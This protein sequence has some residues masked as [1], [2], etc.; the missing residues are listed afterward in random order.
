MNLGQAVAICL[1][2]LRRDST[3]AR[4]ALEPRVPAPSEDLERL[5]TVLLDMLGR[6]GYVNERSNASAELKARRLVRR[7]RLTASDADVWTGMFRQ[8]RWKLNRNAGPSDGILNP[9]DEGAGNI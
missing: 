6:S 4:T 7:L 9:D 8:I 3:A 1:Y 5:T 2:E